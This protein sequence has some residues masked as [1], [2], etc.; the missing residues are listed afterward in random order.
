MHENARF[1]VN[2]LPIG[3]KAVAVLNTP[4]VVGFAS[5]LLASLVTEGP[6]RRAN[7]FPR[8]NC[9]RSRGRTFIPSMQGMSLSVV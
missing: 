3:G 1:Y 7:Q 8:R 5:P 6:A 9:T 2:I 4:K